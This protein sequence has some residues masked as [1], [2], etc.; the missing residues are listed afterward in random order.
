MGGVNLCTA[1]REVFV[2]QQFGKV[3][4]T[5]SINAYRPSP[6]IPQYGS[7]KIGLIYFA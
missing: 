1:F 2:K 5:S 6:L 7:V 4:V 3:V